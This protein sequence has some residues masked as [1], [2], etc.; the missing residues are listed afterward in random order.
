[1]KVHQRAMRDSSFEPVAGDDRRIR[2]VCS[3]ETVGRDN[4]VLVSGG[5]DLRNYRENPVWL[6]GH[7]PNSPVARSVEINATA[8]GKLVAL[9]EFPPAGV[10]PKA[11]EVLG[12]LRAKTI[13]AASTGFDEL[14]GEP[15]DP[16]DHSRGWRITRSE[17]MEMSF[18]TIPAVPDA[19]AGERSAKI[20]RFPNGEIVHWIA[21]EIGEQA[22]DAI[23]R[24]LGFGPKWNCTGA[25]DLDVIDV[26]GWQ[27]E[28]A[29][30]RVFAAA[31]FDGENPDT[32]MAAR[33]FGVVDGN[34]PLIKRSYGLPF[35]D[36]VDGKLVATR[37]GLASVS[38]KVD[39][40][41]IPDSAKL[42]VRSMLTKY[43]IVDEREVVA[44][45]KRTFIQRG[46]WE[47]GALAQTLAELG[48]AQDC[49]TWEA[50]MEQDASAVP[51]MLGEA[52]R[53]VGEALIAMT[54]E[55]VAE[56]MARFDTPPETDDL[57]EE[58]AAIVTQAKSPGAQRF[59]AGKFRQR[60]M[61]ASR[62]KP[63]ERTVKRT[64]RHRARM[65]E[66][67]ALQGD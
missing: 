55:E 64:R 35:G 32:V 2:M 39:A 63:V 11:D 50:E 62:V 51:A 24:S 13:R 57:D 3:T 41:D 43:G 20:G 9:V 56:M 8:D 47:V 67:L 45:V 27:A 1:M 10:S 65:L 49:A 59:L 42:C 40:A 23:K 66:L 34:A 48:W 26:E 17:L 38:A 33:A 16:A 52:M 30:E 7:D 61:L 36:I 19:L 22:A 29:V 37:A 53:L 5:I 54:A 25:T 21:R 58:E 44:S 12:L 31:G 14:D 28:E 4:I 60:H 18:V 15:V 46:M 6:W